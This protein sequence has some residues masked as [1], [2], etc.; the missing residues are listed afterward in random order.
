MAILLQ[1]KA[2]PFRVKYLKPTK[3]VLYHTGEERTRDFQY[4]LTGFAYN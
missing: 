2:K 1:V 4:S 3:K